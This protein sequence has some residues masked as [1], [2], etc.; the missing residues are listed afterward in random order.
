MRGGR[1]QLRAI[2]CETRD[3]ALMNPAPPCKSPPMPAAA[4][5]AHRI[6]RTAPHSPL[7]LAAPEMHLQATENGHWSGICASLCS[8]RAAACSA[9]M[10]RQRSR[11]ASMGGSRVFPERSESARRGR[12]A[13]SSKR[14]PLLVRRH[15]P[16]SWM[17]SRTAIGGRGQWPAHQALLC[18]LAALHPVC[19]PGSL[20]GALPT[21]RMAGR[22]VD[23][24][25][26]PILAAGRRPAGRPT[27]LGL[28]AARGTAHASCR[29][30]GRGYAP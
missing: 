18:L 21:A 23:R 11:A 8:R 28:S 14:K 29:P 5:A 9:R 4:A 15:V 13:R 25:R 3:L 20:S 19:S 6:R 12:R 24:P 26:P 17:A 10:V 22:A 30:L 16:H 2:A 27:R 7:G 1:G